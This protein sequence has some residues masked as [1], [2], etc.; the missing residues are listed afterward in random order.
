MQ[1]AIDAN[2][3]GITSHIHQCRK[4]FLVVTDGA[5]C[6]GPLGLRGKPAV[7]PPFTAPAPARTAAADGLQRAQRP[8]VEAS[9]DGITA[10]TPVEPTPRTAD[11][12]APYQGRQ[13]QGNSQE[14]A[15]CYSR[16]TLTAQS[17]HTLISLLP[18][19]CEGRYHSAV[20]A[21]PTTIRQAA[22]NISLY[23]SELPRHNVHFH[24][25]N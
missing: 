8:P 15:P 12:R 1:D 19:G 6:A 22:N 21:P 4:S 13:H 18:Q 25:S 23:D 5:S 7:L 20:R 24:T 11:R 2:T 9:I 16:H 10:H 14:R 17:P 3:D